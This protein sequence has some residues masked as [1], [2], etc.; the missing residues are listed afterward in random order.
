MVHRYV[1]YTKF[2]PE[3]RKG[4]KGNKKWKNKVVKNRKSENEEKRKKK[5]RIEEGKALF[6]QVRIW[7]LCTECTYPEPTLITCTL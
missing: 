2:F 1:C 7:Q 5:G 3:S 4:Q 6:P